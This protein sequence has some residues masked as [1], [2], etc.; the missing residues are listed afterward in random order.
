VY[1][2][3]EEA[4]MKTFYTYLWLRDYPCPHCGQLGEPY[5][6]GKGSGRRV[7]RKHR[8]GGHFLCP[9]KDPTCVILQ[10]WPDEASALEGEK[11]LICMY[12]RIDRGAGCLRNLSYGGEGI[13]GWVPTE[14][15]RK[16]MSSSHLGV[17]KSESHRRHIGEKHKGMKRS[18]EAC[19]R[20]QFAQFKMSRLYPTMIAEK[21]R[22]LQRYRGG[23]S[24]AMIAGGLGTTADTVSTYFR[25]WG[26]PRRTLSEA[27]KVAVSKGR[28]PNS[29]VKALATRWRGHVIPPPRKKIDHHEG[30]RIGMC[31]RWNIRRDKLCTCGHH[32]SFRLPPVRPLLCA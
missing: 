12:G 7:L 13:S 9:P 16:R 27:G 21:D 6:V 30:G 26:E 24:L 4:Y 19:V 17:S 31:L 10:E 28:R 8:V 5:Y 22:I 15:T 11:F 1:I 25:L 32:I 2:I 18:P 23:E 29:I 14:E 20:M 3:N